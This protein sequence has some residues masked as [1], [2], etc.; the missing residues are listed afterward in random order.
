MKAYE[1]LFLLNSHKANRDWDQAFAHV[2]NILAKHGAELVRHEK[3][4]ERK[5]AY[6]VGRERRGIYLL[7][8]FRASG[9]AVTGIYRDVEISDVVLR[10][11]ILAIKD[12]PPARAEAA[13]APAAKPA[14][15]AAD[16]GKAEV[17]AE[18]EEAAAPETTGDKAEATDEKEET[19]E[20]EAVGDESEAKDEKDDKDESAEAPAAEEPAADV[21][22]TEAEKG[23]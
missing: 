16:S 3:W 11:M 6:T 21:A 5:L 19:A 2:T 9:D 15:P 14:R 20:L 10:A 13:P 12:V 1:G 17:E 18:K 8:Y 23:E 22:D 7:I 4:G